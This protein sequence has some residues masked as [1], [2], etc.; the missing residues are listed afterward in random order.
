MPPFY[1][2]II[3]AYVSAPSIIKASPAIPITSAFRKTLAP[4]FYVQTGKLNRK[5]LPFDR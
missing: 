4:L 2:S 1:A 3:G 5:M